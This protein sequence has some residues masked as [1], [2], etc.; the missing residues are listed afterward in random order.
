MVTY[1][2]LL[3]DIRNILRK[4]PTTLHQSIMRHFRDH[5]EKDLS[6]AI[7][8]RTVGKN[9]IYRLISE[10]RWIKT[11]QTGFPHG[12]NVKIN[13]KDSNDFTRVD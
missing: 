12:C 13:L 6:V 1:S 11:L 8:T 10:E 9:K 2:K 5:E 7:L 4:H 3:P